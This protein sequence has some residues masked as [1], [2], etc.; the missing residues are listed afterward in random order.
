MPSPAS[1][2]QNQPGARTKAG[3]AVS[4][5]VWVA[6]IGAFIWC[7]T[8]SPGEQE[9]HETLETL[10]TIVA[11]FGA[12]V[13]GILLLIDLIPYLN[14]KRQGGMRNL[15]W[16]G[17]VWLG[18]WLTAFVILAIVLGATA[19]VFERAWSD[20]DL[21]KI[22]ITIVWTGLALLFLR[23]AWELLKLPFNR[24]VRSTEAAEDKAY[25]KLQHLMANPDFAGLEAKLSCKLPASY[26]ALFARGSEWL[27]EEWMLYPK[28]L[29]NDEEIYDVMELEPACAESVR[30]HKTRAEP[31]I[32]IARSE[33]G[34]YL[35][36]SGND[37]PPVFHE[38]IAGESPDEPFCQISPRLSEF[39]AWP[40]EKV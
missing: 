12:P 15:L 32:C 21:T 38:D 2:R 37:D 31:L 6:A 39:L 26:K 34:E 25:E 9:R 19:L 20:L 33:F 35:I 14:W 27:A 28:G 4:F 11:T 1:I 5:A 24:S 18:C 23:L 17:L 16:R 30:R 29:D 10:A 22:I 3:C 36:G 40:K 7:A 8:L 13:L